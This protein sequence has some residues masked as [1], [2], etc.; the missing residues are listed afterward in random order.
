[1]AEQ[2]AQ[3]G[4]GTVLGIAGAITVTPSG[5]SDAG[6]GMNFSSVGKTSNFTLDELANS[7]GSYIESAIASKAYRDLAVNFIAKG[8][9]RAN[10]E[11]VIDTFDALTPL[12]VITIASATVSAINIAGN[13][14]PGLTTNLT[15]EGRAEINFTI[16]QYQDSSG[17]FGALTA[18]S[19]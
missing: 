1:M 8:T 5:G 9:T 14:L 16:R 10:A 4:A 7:G 6:S 3:I 2:D 19:G 12:K 17:T 15:R 11:S 18:I 13:L